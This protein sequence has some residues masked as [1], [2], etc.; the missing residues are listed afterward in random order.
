[1]VCSVLSIMQMLQKTI[2]CILTFLFL[3][4]GAAILHA[5]ALAAVNAPQ[6]RSIRVLSFKDGHS[7]AVQA[8]LPEFE[9][10]TGIKV[11]M[12]LIPAPS[13]AAKVLTDQT[14]GAGYDVYLVDEPYLPQLAPFLL[15]YE[16]WPGHGAEPSPWRSA[17]VAPASAGAGFR[18]VSYGLPVNG[19]V[20]LYIYR[21]DWFEDPA[22]R[23]AFKKRYGVELAPPVDVQ[24]FS[25][26]AEFFYRPP[27]RYGFAP[28]TRSSEGTTV[29]AVW[30]FGLLG[31]QLFDQDLK[32]VASPDQVSEALGV[33]RTLMGYAPPGSRM[34]HHAE[35]MRAYSRGLIAHMMT[36]PSFLRDLEDPNKSLVVGKT[37]YG[38]RTTSLRSEAPPTNFEKSG[39][40]GSW[41]LA[42]SKSTPNAQAATEFARWWAGPGAGERLVPKG[43]N[44]ARKDLLSHVSLIQENPW[45]GAILNSFE[46]AQLRPRTQRYREVSQLISAAFT[47]A[48]TSGKPGSSCANC[49]EI[50]MSLVTK[51]RDQALVKE[52]S[53]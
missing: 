7:M 1:M 20:Y 18:G 14:G 2:L 51:L 22:E 10:A 38:T 3:L 31:V 25:R 26:I 44:P 41:I 34:W 37:G 49:Q 33:Y 16:E 12:D 5:S 29:E 43:M 15:P 35:R 19:N 6:P 23:A 47:S 30:L 50:G 27:H 17:F 24:S 53:Q 13:V 42:L 48:V 21:K 36:W 32:V 46:H 40:A 11:T 9:Q 45:F 52:S 4:L 39:V 8:M 28:F